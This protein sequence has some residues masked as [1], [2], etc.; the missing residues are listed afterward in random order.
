MH[1]GKN[2]EIKGSIYNV[3]A[4]KNQERIY[5]LYLISYI[6]LLKYFLLELEQLDKIFLIT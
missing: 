2:Q 5:K 1:D 6:Y 4:C 3:V